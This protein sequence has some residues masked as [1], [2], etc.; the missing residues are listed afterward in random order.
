M[1]RYYVLERFELMKSSVIS[2]LE[3]MTI[4]RDAIEKSRKHN[5]IERAREQYQELE[6]SRKRLADNILNLKMLFCEADME[7]CSIYA[8][9]LYA[10]VSKFHLLTSDYT[11]FKEAFKPL[12]ASIPDNEVTD[13][14]V[15]GRLMNNIRTGYYPTDVEH[16]KMIKNSIV[17]PEGKRINVFDPCCGCGT[18]LDVLTSGKL[19]DTYGIELD[20]MRGEE[21]E[22]CLDRV[23]FGSFFHSRV[24]REAFHMLF[25]NPPYLSVLKEGGGNTRSEKQFLVDGL[26]HLMDGGLLMYIIPFYRL[27]SDIARI[28]CDNFK[29]IQ[30]FR[31]KDDEFKKF[32]QILVMGIKKSKGDGSVDAERMVQ[33][34]SDMEN[35]PVI[36]EL[37]GEHY[38]L[39]EQEKKVDLFKGAVFNLG[40]LQRQLAG[41]KSMEFLFEKSALDAREKRP[42]LP[43]NTGQIG[44]IGGS[45][46]INGYIDCESPH[47]LKGRIIKQTKSLD[48][49]DGTLTETRVN[50][51]IFNVLT[52]Q[53]FKSL[54]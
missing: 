29:D 54:A 51:M 42:L 17:F 5:K 6:T 48:N 30:M 36:T 12:L 41:S 46:L 43:L 9:K 28:L 20:E 31:F 16:V 34:A 2:S 4:K 27:T 11:K 40:E 26:Y 24:S 47:I 53:G 15:V 19:A 1:E 3:G 7:T 18:A 22:K 45:G 23:G 14:S 49:G 25:L 44:L 32:K 38:I 52:P 39:P 10:A 13:A 8:D 33:L 50:K 21:A 35:I 37:E